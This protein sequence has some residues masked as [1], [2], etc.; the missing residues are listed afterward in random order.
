MQCWCAKCGQIIRKWRHI[1]FFL[2]WQTCWHR[3]KMWQGIQE[4]LSMMLTATDQRRL[5]Y[6]QEGRYWWCY[7]RWTA[8]RMKID[9]WEPVPSLPIA[10]GG[11]ASCKYQEKYCFIKGCDVAAANLCNQWHKNG[12]LIK[13]K[14]GTA[15][16]EMRDSCPHAVHCS[17]ASRSELF[18]MLYV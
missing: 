16:Q 11:V 12:C 1:D 4:E 8:T 17:A 6:A 18:Y 2:T 15:L 9:G 5:G 3:T 14:C 13:R 7:G 10:P